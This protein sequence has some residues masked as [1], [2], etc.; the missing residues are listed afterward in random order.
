MQFISV[1]PKDIPNIRDSHRG[2]VSY[3]ILKSFLET[4]MSLA[5]LD[6]T[7]LQQSLMGLNSCLN[8]YI[9]SHDLPIKIFNRKGEIY[10]CRTDIDDD[11]NIIVKEEATSEARPLDAAE[12]ASR[13]LTEQ[14]AFTK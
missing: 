2:R 7:G 3:P 5:Q 4:N 1:D 12:V 13:L 10:L 11:G 9:K 8:S 14:G 6:R